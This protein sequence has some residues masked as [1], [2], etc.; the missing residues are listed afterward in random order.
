MGEVLLIAGL[1][2]FESVLEEIWR[3][4]TC[5]SYGRSSK[6]PLYSNMLCTVVVFEG[7]Y[8][9]IISIMWS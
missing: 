3:G 8:R 2:V 7:R 6:F 4:F 5:A 9:G 1:L